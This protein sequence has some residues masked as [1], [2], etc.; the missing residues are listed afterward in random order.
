MPKHLYA[1]ETRTVVTQTWKINST[2]A[3]STAGVN[4]PGTVTVTYVNGKFEK[5]EVPAEIEPGSRN[6]LLI[7]ESV[8]EAVAMFEAPKEQAAAV[9]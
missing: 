9:R 5:F 4:R 8:A 6:Y 1:L 7:A 3:G 2:G